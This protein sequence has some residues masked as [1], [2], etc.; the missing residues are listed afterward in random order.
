MFPQVNGTFCQI[1]PP[2]PAPGR[3]LKLGVTAR[4]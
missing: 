1:R 2:L 4:F 3:T